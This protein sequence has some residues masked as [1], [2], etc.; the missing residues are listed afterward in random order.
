M[1]VRGGRSLWS[2]LQSEGLLKPTKLLLTHTKAYLIR[3]WNFAS[4][5]LVFL[6]VT[7]SWKKWEKEEAIISNFFYVANCVVEVELNSWT[8]S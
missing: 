7:N 5:Q 8:K 2:P 3:V 6:Y 4:L 1:R